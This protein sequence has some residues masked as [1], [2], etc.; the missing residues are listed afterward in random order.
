M[1]RRTRWVNL[2]IIVWVMLAAK[3]TQ[4]VESVLVLAYAISGRWRAG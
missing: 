3:E 1:S 2:G 4:A